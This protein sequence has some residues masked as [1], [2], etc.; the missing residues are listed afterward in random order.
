MKIWASRLPAADLQWR[1][2]MPSLKWRPFVGE[3]VWVDTWLVAKPVPITSLPIGNVF[4]LF[5]ITWTFFLHSSMCFKDTDLPL[6]AFS[7]W[8]LTLL[9]KLSHHSLIILLV[10]LWVR[11]R[12]LNWNVRYLFGA[13][14]KCIWVLNRDTPETAPFCL[15]ILFYLKVM[16]MPLI[17]ILQCWGWQNR[18]KKAWVF[19]ETK[20]SCAL[21]LLESVFGTLCFWI[22]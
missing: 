3:C 12:L 11:N 5:N 15:W 1:G 10:N 22:V 16:S 8:I 20:R 6:S 13:S 17:A 2:L 19:D 7:T 9:I 21:L 14:G 4:P 18:E